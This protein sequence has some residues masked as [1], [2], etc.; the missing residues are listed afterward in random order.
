M[1]LIVPLLVLMK[2]CD[3]K[4]LLDDGGGSIREGDGHS[5]FHSRRIVSINSSTEISDICCI[6]NT[7]TFFI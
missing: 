3:F 7:G 1:T 6:V 5:A 4:L 2:N